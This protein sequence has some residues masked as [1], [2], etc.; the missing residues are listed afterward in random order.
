MDMAVG[1]AVG[2]C[3]GCG[4]CVKSRPWRSQVCGFL[5][6]LWVLCEPVYGLWVVDDDV[7]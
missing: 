5:Y 6:G 4:F 3:D 7:V 2:G 1:D